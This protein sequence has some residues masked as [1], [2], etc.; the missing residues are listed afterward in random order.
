MLPLF[1]A[2]A[3]PGVLQPCAYVLPAFAAATRAATFCPS[4]RSGTARRDGCP[5]NMLGYLCAIGRR[6]TGRVLPP[7]L[8]S[9]ST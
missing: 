7:L 3:C 8:L 4:L 2:W 6:S 5:A 1:A 9:G